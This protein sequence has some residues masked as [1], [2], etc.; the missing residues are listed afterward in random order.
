MRKMLNSTTNYSEH[1]KLKLQLGTNSD[2]AKTENP[3]S[4]KIYGGKDRSE[5]LDKAKKFVNL[6]HFGCRL[7]PNGETV[8]FE[9]QGAGGYI[10]ERHFGIPSNSSPTSDFGDVELKTYSKNRIT[11]FQPAPDSGLFKDDFKKAMSRYGHQSGN[12]IRFNGIY[13]YGEEKNG[14]VLEI[15]EVIDGTKVVRFNRKGR[16]YD[17]ALAHNLYVV[18][19][20]P[21]EPLQDKFVASWPMSKLASR[22]TSKHKN[23][24]YFKSNKTKLDG[25][26]V[27]SYDKTITWCSEPSIERLVEAII[28]GMIFLDPSSSLDLIDGSSKRRFQWRF[29]KIDESLP[30]IYGAIEKIDLSDDEHAAAPSTETDIADN[31]SDSLKNHYRSLCLT[32][33]AFIQ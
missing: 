10:L 27:Y 33:T 22:M 9:G 15:V 20:D 24:V 1:S 18:L 2:F 8:P 11:L 7:L 12:K 25:K 6:S 19:L 31:E 3:I 14:L 32:A 16:N 28:D 5:F 13:K 26:S 23:I 21:A 29:G 4:R 30:R 17:G